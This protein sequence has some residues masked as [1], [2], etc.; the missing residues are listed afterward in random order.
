MT[1][2]RVWITLFLVAAVAACQKDT[3][4]VKAVIPPLA[5]LRYFDA[6]LDTGYMDMR[7]VDIVSYAP[8]SVRARFRTGG[9]PLGVSNG[10]L[11]PP[12]L[13][14]QTGAHEI[15]AFLDST[16]LTTAT[17]VM[18]DTTV[19]FVEGHNYT[20]ILYGRA[21]ATNGLHSLIVDDAPMALPADNSIWVRTINLATSL[22]TT[23]IGATP[24]DAYAI[25]QS[26]SAAA[27]PTIAGASSVYGRVS[28]YVR[29][30]V[31]SL[32]AVLTRTGTVTAVGTAV[33]FLDGAVGTS[34]SDPLAG[35]LVKNTAFSIVMLPRSTPGAGMPF[36]YAT[37]GAFILIDQQP[38]RTVQ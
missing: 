7:L 26:S 29:V 5:G 11:S 2:K 32:Q 36:S 34:T 4:G 20:F 17:K 14:V 1:V 35:A 18:Y 25:P 3:A 27:P 30:P 12:F 24:P 33:N 13:S 19:T 22:D 6:V 8:N 16:D 9:D 10:A 37:P 28:A 15:K 23:G 31:G 38:P 21:R